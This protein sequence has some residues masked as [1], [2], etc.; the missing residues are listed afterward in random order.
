ME[1][2]SR[3]ELETLRLQGGRS[4]IKAIAALLKN[5]NKYLLKK[6][7]VKSSRQAF[8][9]RSQEEHSHCFLPT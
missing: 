6:E 9:F 3:L 2:Q 4:T 7:N 8:R 5:K 1:P